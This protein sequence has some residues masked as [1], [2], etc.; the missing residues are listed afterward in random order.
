MCVWGKI[1]EYSA[2]LCVC[3]CTSPE[4]HQLHSGIYILYIHSAVWN[5]IVQSNM[6][7]IIMAWISMGLCMSS[8]CFHFWK[9]KWIQPQFPTP[10]TYCTTENLQIYSKGFVGAR[11]VLQSRERTNHISDLELCPSR[12]GSTPKKCVEQLQFAIVPAW[13]IE[14][15]V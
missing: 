9:R 13:T 6:L 8:R 12:L 1:S 4:R 3:V 15:V 2:N 10:V 5:D 11:R 7:L 14:I